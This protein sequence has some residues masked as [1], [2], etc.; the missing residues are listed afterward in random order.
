[1]FNKLADIKQRLVY[2]VFLL[3]FLCVHFCYRSGTFV[4]SDVWEL[5]IPG[6]L[7]QQAWTC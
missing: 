4:K 5:S 7:K 3:H 6:P 2:Y 1:M